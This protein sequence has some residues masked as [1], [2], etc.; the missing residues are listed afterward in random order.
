M[1]D[2]Y[3]ETRDVGQFL[4]PRGKDLNLRQATVAGIE[5]GSIQL[6]FSDG[7]FPVGGFNFLSSYR[8]QIGDVVWVLKQGGDNLV[9]GDIVIP[10]GLVQEPIH[11]VGQ[12]DYGEPAFQNNWQNYGF[13][14]AFTYDS[15]GFYKDP[16]GFVHLSGVVKNTSGSA[17]NTTIFTL[18]AGYRPDYTH[19]TPVSSNAGLFA[20]KLWAI[21]VQDDGQVK[22]VTASNNATGGSVKGYL[23]LEGIR[24]MAVE[25]Q[26]ERV[27]EWVGLG[28]AGDWTWDYS[29]QQD[30]FPSQWHRWDGLVRCRGRLSNSVDNTQDLV[31]V[32]SEQSSR[33]RW[34]KLLPTVMIKSSDSSLQAVRLDVQPMGRQIARVTSAY[35]NELLLDGLQWYGDVP[36]SYW[37]ELDLVNSWINYNAAPHWG[38]ARFFKDGYGV[39]HVRGLVSGGTTTINT[40]VTTLPIDCRPVARKMFPTWHAAGGGSA[41]RLD[42]NENGE[43]SISSGGINAG[44]MTLDTISFRSNPDFTY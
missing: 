31:A 20:T 8:P 7:L 35:D 24:F 13:D 22:V 37:T 4:I 19:R 21:D 1:S 33:T 43:V 23:S 26:H 36:E 38:Q 17:Y 15:A 40:I 5:M 12:T 18:P 25:N 3:A 41:G 27:H 39:V 9:L 6:L 34:S 14:G 10:G 11:Y 29:I 44:H 42:V 28:R 30:V 2:L 32:I 16:D